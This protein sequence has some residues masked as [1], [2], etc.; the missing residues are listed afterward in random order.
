A[1]K[2]EF[3]TPEVGIVAFQGRIAAYMPGARSCKREKICTEGVCVCSTVGPER[4][5]DF[6]AITKPFVMG[7]S[8]LNDKSLN[9]VGMRQCHSKAHRAT[10][11]LHVERVAIKPERFGEASDDLCVVVKGIRKLLWVWPIAVPKARV[12]GRDKMEVIGK[13]R[14]QRLE[15]P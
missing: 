4:A 5:P 15:H 13:T 1:E 10:V 2:G 14:K 7:D 8:V 6:P 11:V 12:I 9:A 3:V